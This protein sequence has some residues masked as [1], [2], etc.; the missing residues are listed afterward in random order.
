MDRIFFCLA[1]LAS[2]HHVRLAHNGE[3]MSVLRKL[4][5]PIH[6]KRICTIVTMRRDTRTWPSLPYR[7][8]AKA[9]PLL[10]PVNDVG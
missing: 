6:N 8:R 2:L 4:S 5:E 9:P 1:H 7:I 3:F 10:C